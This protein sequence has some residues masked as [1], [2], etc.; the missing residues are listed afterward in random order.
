MRT[1]SLISVL[2][3]AL[4]PPILRAAD[5]NRLTYLDGN[6]PYYVSRTFPKLTTPQWVGEPGVEAV[7]VLAI[8][9]MRDPTQY[10]TFLRPILRRLQ[11]IDGRAPV[12]IMTNQV[13]PQHPRLQQWLREGLSLET[14]TID[15]P[16]PF[17]AGDFAKSRSTYD[18]CVDLMNRV[19][20]NKPV[21]F[22]MPCCDSL[23]TQSP[24]FFTEI[25]N[26]TTEE[27]NFLTLDSSV[28]NVLTSNDPDLPR[29]LVQNADGR[30]RFLKYLP[31]DRSFVNTIEDYPYPYVIGR[32]CWEFPCVVPSDWEANHYHKPN[33]PIT[34][35][36]LEAALDAIVIKQG[37]FNLVF[38]PH[39][40]IKN[41][42]VVEFIDH[43]VARHG[44]KVKFLTFREAQERLN[45]NLLAGQPLRAANGQDNGVRLIDVNNDGYLDVV[46]G[47]D[48]IR[49]TRVWSPSTKSWTVTNFPVNL[50]TFDP[51]GNRLDA[52]VRFG[53]VRQ[54]GHATLLVRNEVEAGAWSFGGKRWIQNRGGVTLDLEVAGQPVFTSRQGRDLGV[55]LRDLDGDGRCE[56]IVS[57]DRQQAVFTLSPEK[58]A[59]SKLPFT[60][61]AGAALVNANGQDNGIRFADLDEDGQDDVIFSNENGYGLYLFTSM[62]KGWTRKAVVGKAGNPGA[63][64][65]I[66]RKGTNNGAWFHSRHLWVHNENTALLKDH[67]DRRS[68]NELLEAVEPGAKTAEASLR[69]WRTRPGFEVEL[70]AA[71][72]LIEDPVAFAWGPDG[73]LWV[74]EMT[75]YPLGVDGKGSPGGRIKYLEDTNGD[76]IYTKATLF[77][78]GLTMPTGVMPWGKGVIVTC[79]PEIFYA[80]D[81]D[82]DGRAD[83]KKPLYVG[84]NPGNPQHRINGLVWGLDNWVYVANGDSGGVVRSVKTGAEVD[85]RGRDLRLRPD[86]GLLETQTG[87]TQFGRS[88]DDW[89]NW[90]GCNNTDP[91]YHFVLDD[92]Y[93]R[94]NPHVAAPR[95]VVQVS[96]T[97][98]PSRVYPVSRTLPR[99]NDPGG[100]NHF[101]S[102]CSV[103]VYRDDLFGPHFAGNSFVSEPV[104]DLVHREIMSPKGVTFTSQCA[105]DEQQSEFLAS[106]D[107]WTRPTTIK[108][109]PDGALWVAD[110]YRQVIEH[111]EWIPKDWQ[112][113]LDLRAGH[114]KGRIYRVYPVGKRPR[115]IPRLDQLDTASLVAALDSPSGWQRDMA[116]QMLV[117]KQDA[118][119]VPLLEKLAAENSRPLC[120]LHAL[121]TLD[122]LGA[123]KP[124][125]LKKA[126]ADVHPGIRRHAV[127]LCEGRLSGAVDLGASLVKLVGDTDPQVRMQLAYTLGEWDDP[128]AGEALGKL[129]VQEGGDPY[130]SAAVMSSLTKKN[131]ETVLIT[132]LSEHRTVPP[133]GL[134]ENLLRVANA[135]GTTKT[136]A[137]LLTRVATPEKGHFAPW[138]YAALA[139][140]LDT[141]DQRNTTLAQL[142]TRD[143]PELKAVLQRVP[144]VF[145][146]ARASMADRL[147]PRAVQLQ[148]IRL[149][150]RG[151][152][153][154]QLDLEFLA[155]LLVPQTAEE[156]QAA[157]VAT[158]GKLH[159][160]EVP[161]VLLRGWKGYG[162][163]LRSQTLDVLSRRD[164]WLKSMLDALESK[165]ILAFEV[166]AARRQRLLQ[167]REAAVRE[168]AA[169]LLAGAIDP[170]RQK[171]VEAYQ[172]VLALKGDAR[173]GAQVFAKNCATC[174]HFGGVGHQVGPDLAS[175]GDKS[176]AGLLIAILDPNRA[177]EA[178]YINYVA[179]TKNGLTLNGVLANETGTSITLVG[180]DGKQQVILRTDL[181]ELVSSNRSVMPE[182]LEKDLKPQDLAD[183]IAHLRTGLP[184]AK[185]KS[186]PGNKPEVVRPAA[187]GSLRLLA[188]NCAIYGSTLGLDPLRGKLGDW[189]SDDDEV[190][191]T[192]EL[193]RP[194]KYAV[195]LDW[196]C[197]ND[198][199][200]QTLVLQAGINRL[201]YRVAGTGSWDNFRQAKIG[202]LTLAAGQQEVVLRA[203]AKLTGPLIDLKTVKLVPLSG[204]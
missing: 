141:L 125:L 187:D 106:S 80:E 160:R 66:A 173:R 62:E 140:L 170:D 69:S 41:E 138:Q 177:L 189:Q 192:V 68:F 79:A 191:W 90:F 32:L 15:H 196:S 57:N 127:R 132:V 43:A 154:Q 45:R 27:G 186:F 83:V 188:T 36:D 82:G 135:F 169:R 84:F 61:P 35:R 176:P 146:A 133:A 183:L 182:G 37:V 51:R 54:D 112:K 91:M 85:M 151:V 131:L 174:H 199:A 71:E 121:C 193:A 195:W 60:L 2:V 49:Q 123:L 38:H 108:T 20:G 52:G 147:A 40:W 204:K 143:D 93:L 136:L 97:P 175:V 65:L 130:L 13:D 23:N 139:G 55:R 152:D 200:G 185:A 29:E 179:V 12:S 63:L 46:I 166:D 75:D 203:A 4:T 25:F 157:A 158:L 172:S 129:A 22:R 167:H 134:V 117:Q 39:G 181:E 202:E 18:R 126:L 168:R 1:L 116:Q 94:R 67:V 137:T 24:R 162:P 3:L 34:V 88:R 58:N 6:D 59:W 95:P 161:Q 142:G 64:P 113:R 96:V 153:H 31:Y 26:K 101:T 5:G 149:L 92:H 14:H 8:D 72:P 120:R 11:R 163:A 197:R 164:E 99:F 50:V 48:S 155:G 33:N 17:F 81:T 110:M 77:L 10:E 74:V 124:A 109:G 103:I 19:P 86:Q 119:A 165:Q 190:T 78:D 122:G 107:N 180:P 7:V 115:A 102:A 98:G 9:D 118:A 148:A 111:P 198:A 28:F 156:L 53:I 44:K 21:A 145:A 89:G 105:P 114:D 47:N 100:A 159:G 194:G 16:C 201:T 73:K 87:Q 30:D 56:L 42:Q 178:R 104:H 76:G 70:V 144:A 184:A 171:V 150:G 128:R